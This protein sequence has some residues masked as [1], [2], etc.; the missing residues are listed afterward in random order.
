MS[1]RLGPCSNGILQLTNILTGLLH[2][3][4]DEVPKACSNSSLA[5][6]GRTA[7]N[8]CVLTTFQFPDGDAILAGALAIRD[9]LVRLKARARRASIPVIY[10]NDNFGDW[11]SE[12]EVLIGRC[13]E[14]KG[15]DF[16]RP[17]L[18]DSED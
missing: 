6:T 10:V 14:A 11:R 17:L 7:S 8:R 16:V 4:T 9:D 12:K 18:P 5:G 2:Q 15:K 1:Q 3:T 13:L